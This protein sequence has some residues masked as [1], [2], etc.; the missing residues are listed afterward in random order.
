MKGA[1]ATRNISLMFM[2]CLDETSNIGS[3]SSC[4]VCWRRLRDSVFAMSFF[5]L[6]QSLLISLLIFVCFFSISYDSELH[7]GAG[8]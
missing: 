3:F 7:C 5:V 6:F 4:A 1:A 2:P 8:W